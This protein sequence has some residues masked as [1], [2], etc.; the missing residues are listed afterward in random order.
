[1]TGRLSPYR[2]RM[3]TA[4]G[5]ERGDEGLVSPV[6]ELGVQPQRTGGRVIDLTMTCHPVGGGAG[7][8]C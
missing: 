7:M 5:S 8:T 3:G 1:M 4:D 2:A 6:G